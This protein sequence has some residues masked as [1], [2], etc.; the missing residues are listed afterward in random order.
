MDS[1]TSAHLSE[2]L[3]LLGRLDG[4]LQHS[5]A[6][7]IFLARARL[8]GAV[9]LSGLAGVPIKV[10]DLQDW[11]SGR[12]PPP[13]ASEGLN[14]P[15]SVAAVFH[16]AISIDEDSRDPLMRATLNVL[17]TVLDDRAEAEAYAQD[18]LAHFG[19]C[20]RRVREAADQRYPSAG[21]EA[22]AERVFELAALTEAEADDG[23]KV[24]T[25]D[26]RS[27]NLPPRARDRNWVVAA[28]LPRMLHRAG[29]T[30][31]VIPSLILLP[32][33]LPSMPAE[34]VDDMVVMLRKAVD[35]ALRDLDTIERSAAAIEIASVA[36]K[37]SKAPILARLKLAYP[38]LKPAAVSRLLGVTPQGARKLL[39]TSPPTGQPRHSARAGAASSR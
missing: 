13:R 26:G 17:R 15:I 7:D 39:A 3:L 28:V 27:L 37:R 2:T 38:G 24:V 9:A 4:R 22:I 31:R 23:I 18:D 19:L 29:L 34:L 21:L 20:W 16:F 6:A 36:T 12:S 5:P 32:K 8:A 33:F 10:Q 30:T 14:D 25:V 1:A 35:D 11:I